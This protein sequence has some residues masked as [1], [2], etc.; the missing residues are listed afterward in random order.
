PEPVELTG[1]RL[2]SAIPVSSL[3]SL[4]V[5]L[6]VNEQEQ[7]DIDSVRL[8][9]RVTAGSNPEGEVVASGAEMMTLPAHNAAGEEIPLRATFDLNSKIPGTRLMEPLALHIWVTGADMVGHAMVSDI[10]FNSPSKP[11]ASWSIQQLNSQMVMGDDDLI[12]SHKGEIELGDEVLLT[13]RML[14]EGEIYGFANV[15]LTEIHSDGST[16]TLTTI[17]EL[18]EAGPGE[19]GS[20][21]FGWTPDRLGHV[22]VVVSVDGEQTVT[23]DS[24][25]VVD[26][27]DADGVMGQLE[28]RGVTQQLL[29]VLAVMAV[30]LVAIALLAIRSKGAVHGEGGDLTGEV[31]EQMA[32]DDR[33]AQQATAEQWA[34][35]QAHAQQQQAG[36]GAYDPTQQGWDGYDQQQY[37]DQYRQQ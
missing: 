27:G 18:I 10:Q 2:D 26:P 17:P 30:L 33:A 36:Y 21:Q 14:N 24:I 32:A 35:W 7:L 34:Q 15:T 37:W 16:R 6:K 31:E 19:V 22:W 9:W 13:V 23:G 8:N 29:M 28:E 5:E 3:R 25:H 20:L 11:F 4:T 12:Y 1:P